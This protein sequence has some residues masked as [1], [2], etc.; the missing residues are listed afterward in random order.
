MDV[1]RVQDRIYLTQASLIQ[2]LVDFMELTDCNPHS[3]RWNLALDS[4]R[5]IGPR[6]QIWLGLNA[7]NILWA[8]FSTLRSGLGLTWDM[9]PMSCR[10][11]KATL[12][13][14]IWMQLSELFGISKVQSIMVWFIGECIRMQIDLSALLMQIGLGILIHDAL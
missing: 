12:A 6:H 2:E 10:N 11:T 7:T 5:L 9:L 13:Q 4:L 8:A 14:F 1:H 3:R